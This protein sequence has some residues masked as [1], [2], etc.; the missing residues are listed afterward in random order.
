MKSLFFE[1]VHRA[2][3]VHKGDALVMLCSS[4]GV[5]YTANA[6]KIVKAGTED[7]E[8][9][10]NKKKNHYFITRLIGSQWHKEVYIVRASK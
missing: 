9:I 6:K 10:Y 5:V 7:E 3:Q 1:R 2:G 8:V 4:Q